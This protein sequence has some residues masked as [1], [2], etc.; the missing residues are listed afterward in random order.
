MARDTEVFKFVLCHNT[1]PTSCLV[2][3]ESHKD[4]GLLAPDFSELSQQCDDGGQ[5]DQYICRDEFCDMS[6]DNHGTML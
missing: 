4:W 6:I 5:D 1:S 3:G 2:S